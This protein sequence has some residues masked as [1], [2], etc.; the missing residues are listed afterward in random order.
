MSRAQSVPVLQSS[1]AQESE[2]AY[3][4]LLTLR[5]AVLPDP[6]RVAS[7]ETDFQSN[8]ATYLACPFQIDGPPD[9]P[10]APPAT[11]LSVQNVDRRIVL[12]VRSIP[13]GA[14]DL[15]VE[16]AVVTQRQPD[17]IEFGPYPLKMK[18]ATYNRLVVSGEL[19]FENILSQPASWA[20][21]T[22][23]DHPGMV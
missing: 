5:H 14:G 10:D 17:T 22:P 13:P 16:M 20:R 8:G 11:Q 23:N 4:V 9:T 21:L 15:D 2:E 1:W 12:G 7:H 3:V 18:S 19:G 6:I